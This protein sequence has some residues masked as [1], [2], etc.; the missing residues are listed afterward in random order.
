M[1]EM[2]EMRKLM[3]TIRR[4]EEGHFKDLDIDLQIL[5]QENSNLSPVQLVRLARD[6]FGQKAATY[7]SNQLEREGDT[8]DY[9]DE[10]KNNKLHLEL[11]N[12]NKSKWRRELRK[13]LADVDVSNYSWG[14]SKKN[15]GEI[16]EAIVTVPAEL[17][18]NIAMTAHATSDDAFKFIKDLDIDDEVSNTVVDPETGEVLFAPGKTKR[19]DMKIA[20]RTSSDI[21][22]RAWQPTMHAGFERDYEKILDTS[23][24]FLNSLRNSNF[25]YVVCRSVSEMVDDSSE[26]M[27]KD[28][29][30]EY[31][32]PVL[33]KRKDGQRLNDVDHKNIDEIIRAVKNSSTMQNVG[34]IFVGT[35]N[36]GTTARFMPS[37]M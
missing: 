23:Y 5:R 15:Y 3:E 9:F 21:D 12:S 6:K 19:E 20:A 13:K 29:D 7:L 16:D 14:K 31:D 32:I 22:R 26:L 28:Y 30:V 10:D 24:D 36:N 17:R 1:S 34:I 11:N 4:I 37:F 8:A 2:S 33:L 18:G 27:N 25:Y 35:T